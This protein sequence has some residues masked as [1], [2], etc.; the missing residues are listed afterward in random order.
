MRGE[1]VRGCYWKILSGR[2]FPMQDC[3]EYEAAGAIW[4]GVGES[5]WI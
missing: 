4:L 2:L 5:L 1:L 3:G